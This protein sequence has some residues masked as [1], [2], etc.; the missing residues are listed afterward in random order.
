MSSRL[1]NITQSCRHS[2]ALFARIIIHA[3]QSWIKNRKSEQLHVEFALNLTPLGS[4]ISVSQLIYMLNGMTKSIASNFCQMLHFYIMR[5]IECMKLWKRK[6]LFINFYLIWL[7]CI[8]LNQY[9]MMSMQTTSMMLPGH[10]N[11]SFQE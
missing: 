4:H 6:R 3:K 5:K 8:V 10:T 11:Q 7:D 2:N 1:K 9:I